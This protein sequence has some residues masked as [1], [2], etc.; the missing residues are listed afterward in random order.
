MS[1]MSSPPSAVGLP[2]WRQE[3]VPKAISSVAQLDTSRSHYFLASHTPIRNIHDD[4]TDAVLSEEELFKALLTQAHN[5]VLAVVHGEPGTGKSH[6]IHW[7]KL[8]LDH[9][10]E[11]NELESVV[12]VLI[13]RRTGSLKDALEQLVQQL[14][15]NFAHYLQPVREALSRI[16]EETA[17]EELAN[18]LRL[19]LSTRRRDRAQP[20]LPSHL[21][22]LG[23]TVSSQGFRTW[24]CRDGGPID[25]NIKRL[26]QSSE[27]E[28]R[29][30][31][32][33]FNSQDF[34]IQDALCRYNNTPQVQDLIDD[35]DDEPEYREQAAVLFN[36]VLPDALKE[37]TGL[38]GNTLREVFDRIRM[39]LA[40]EGRTLAVFVEDVS[41]M[42][43]LDE[44][45]VNAFEPQSRGD[46]CR[47]IAVLG[48]TETGVGHLRDNQL[49]RVTHMVSVGEGTLGTWKRDPAEVARFSARYLNALRLSEEQVKELARRR[50]A[51]GDVS[52]SACDAC[53]VREECHAAFGT[54]DLDGT[55]VGL[56]PF[57][58]RSPQVL[59]SHLDENVKGVRRNPRGLLMHVLHPVLDKLEA[60]EVRDFPTVRLSV[61]LPELLF[62][63]GFEDSYCGG[64]SRRDRERL[65]FLAQAWIQADSADDAA[66]MLKPL[67]KPLGFSEFSRETKTT[68]SSTSQ[69]QSPTGGVATS[70]PPPRKTEENEKLND[71]LGELT[72]WLDTGK[73]RR[74]VEPRDLLA[75]LIRKS[76]RWE[77]QRE[78]PK[79]VWNDHTKSKDI[80]WIE[81]MRAK[82]QES[83]SFV[84]FPRSQETRHLIEAL[85]QYQ[86]VGNESWEFP[87]GERHKRTV[88]RWLRHHREEV[89][90]SLQPRGDLDTGRPVELAV[91]FLAASALIT[92][93]ANLPRE[94]DRL[95]SAILAPP[96]EEFPTALSEPW[97]RWIEKVR[98]QHERV[99]EY[100]VEELSVPQGRT[101]R[102]NFIDPLRILDGAVAFTN[103]PVVDALP[104]AYF[105]QFWQ[106]RYAQLDKL[107]GL[108]RLEN[109]ALVERQAIADRLNNVDGLLRVAGYEGDASGAVQ[110]YCTDL[111]ETLEAQKQA[112]IIIPA[113]DFD[114]LRRRKV[115][116]DRPPTW[117]RALEQACSAVEA[118]N[119]IDVLLFDPTPLEDAAHSL[120]LAQK[121][122][123]ALEKLVEVEL[124]HIEREGDP[125]QIAEA[126][127][128]DLQS[129]ASEDAESIEGGA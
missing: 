17:R 109:V 84:F 67:L 124:D 118:E 78:I 71:L 6:L 126:L 113:E 55:S 50:R 14:P 40:E 105:T 106:S 95:V 63:R 52:R 97:Q 26:S 60:L 66:A 9:A 123:S 48:M 20:P 90:Q 88:S 43:G 79:R 42:S 36:Q 86:Y 54:V 120:E 75:D 89:I 8:R 91:Q 47:T 108:D 31:L 59:V 87:D 74:D 100:L 4:R 116:Q 38:S 85:A 10:L 27:V 102:D 94:A 62:W 19:E 12:P 104:E 107:G 98:G 112:G 65:K 44:D 110:I 22:G 111:L 129:L 3:D 121:Y 35:L 96:P 33:E 81:G 92:R 24:H 41:V 46:L 73:L 70:T 15:V 57:S 51:G 77:D 11:Q 53:P 68:P 122:V 125:D 58:P 34:E 76:I 32:P 21:E 1:V 5:E 117:A 2:C 128:R 61:R 25:R 99:R 64:W 115:F 23:E 103:N 127:L 80:V 101:G 49:E 69:P 37:M 72:G 56:F 114:A 30:T 28:D 93:R 119:P 39:E 18:E 29:E 83:E 45:I 7:L 16:S 13:R 82:K